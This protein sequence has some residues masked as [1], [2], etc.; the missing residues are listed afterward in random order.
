MAKKCF[1]CYTKIDS[2]SVVEMCQKC[3]HQVWGEKMSGA[4]LSN[5]KREKEFGNLELGRVWELSNKEGSF[6]GEEYINNKIEEEIN[7]IKRTNNIQDNSILPLDESENP[8]KE[9]LNT[10]EGNPNIY[11]ENQEPIEKSS[12]EVLNFGSIFGI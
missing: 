12:T 11:E 7:T 6:S 8:T 4:I 2:D 10:T 1:Y 5:V 3:M 9:N